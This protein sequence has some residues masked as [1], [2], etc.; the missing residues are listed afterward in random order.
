MCRRGT[1]R[2]KDGDYVRVR[3]HSD[4]GLKGC[5]MDHGEALERGWRRGEHVRKGRLGA[6]GPTAGAPEARSRARL[7][8]HG[9]IRGPCSECGEPTRDEGLCG[10][11]CK[12]AFLERHGL[13]VRRR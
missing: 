12:P 11:R 6:R 13:R 8:Q 7:L 4:R 10:D 3:R 2:G 9:G 1:P 5:K